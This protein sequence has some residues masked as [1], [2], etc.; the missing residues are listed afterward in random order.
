[1][2]D[3][4]V[5]VVRDGVDTVHLNPGEQCNLDDTDRDRVV[6]EDDEAFAALSSGEA[7]ACQHCWKDAP[8]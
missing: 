8:A 4:Y 5:R 1:M 6:T 2:A 3:R 7:V